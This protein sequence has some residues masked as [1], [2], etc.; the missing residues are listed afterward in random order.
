MKNAIEQ[1]ARQL[2]ILFTS[3]NVQSKT[4]SGGVVS[5]LVK[6]DAEIT[7]KIEV[8]ETE[9]DQ[10]KFRIQKSEQE[11]Q[12]FRSL[13]LEEMISQESALNKQQLIETVFIYFVRLMDAMYSLLL[14]MQR[15]I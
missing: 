8:D 12:Y 5:M 6:W 10:L 1:S 13:L 2:P 3:V 4:G 14:K 15:I 11:H 7:N 9:L